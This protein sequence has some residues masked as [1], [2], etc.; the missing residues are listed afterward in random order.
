[1]K[2][3]DLTATVIVGMALG[4]FVAIPF[5][6]VQ[7]GG[8]VMGQQMGLG[9]AQVIN[10]GADISGDILG[11]MLYIMTMGA[12][13][14]VGGLELLI[15]GVVLSFGEVPL[16]GFALH[17]APLDVVVGLLTAGFELAIRIA[18]PVLAIIFLENVALGFIMKTVPS[19]NILNFGFPIR[20]LIGLAV[21]GASIEFM[22]QAIEQNLGMTSRTMLEWIGSL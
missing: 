5:A 18:M 3:T 6:S 14:W 9:I 16:G 22:R 21:F 10:P 4:I 19:L 11:Q 17:A 12:F 13:V 15:G 8:M 20:I 1:M 2:L 7:L